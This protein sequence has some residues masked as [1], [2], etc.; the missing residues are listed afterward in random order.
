MAHRLSW[1]L[2]NGPP[3]DKYVCHKCDNPR[4]VNPDHLFLGT[5]Q[6]NMDDMVAKGR[7]FAVSTSGAGPSNGAAKL[8]A[9]EVRSIRRMYAAGGQSQAQLGQR[10]GVVGVVVSRVARR[11]SYANVCDTCDVLDCADP[12]HRLWDLRD[13]THRRVGKQDGSNN[14]AAKLTEAKVVEIRRRAAL[15]ESQASIA[16]SYSVSTSSIGLVVNRVTWTHVA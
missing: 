5:H 13:N 3:G 10:F 8:T 11:L 1:E 7:R 9:D 12:G 4:C 6:D 15:G 16:S 2:T 14:N